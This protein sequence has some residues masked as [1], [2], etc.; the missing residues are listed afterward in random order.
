MKYVDEFR[1]GKIAEALALEI[2]KAVTRSWKIMEVC[3]GQTHTV[4]QF[5]LEDLLPAEIELLHGPGCPVC[6]TPVEVIDKAVAMARQP[7]VIMCSFGDMLRVPGS[8]GDLLQAKAEGADVRIVYCPLDALKLARKIPDRRIIFFAIGFET[9]APANAMAVYQAKRLGIKNFFML[10]SHVTVP[11]IMAAILE[12]PSN[13]VQA[14]LGPGHVCSIMGWS[15]YEAISR[16]Y[17]VPIVVT[18]FEPIDLLEGILYCVKQLEL[19]E[20]KVENQYARVVSYA[21]NCGAQSMLSDVFE[22]SDRQWR[23][24]GS[25]AKSGY[26][27]SHAYSQFDAEREF[28]VDAQ[29][30]AESPLCISGEILRGL[31]KPPQ[32]S[33]FGKQCTP[34]H[35]LGATMVS[36]EGTCATYFKF[37]KASSNIF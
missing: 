8:S 36:S 22:V 5:G 2:K 35:P 7:D 6:V 29:N 11:P 12:S 9:T 33:A 27:L 1:D 24:L 34:E 18:G 26:R 15:E 13:H 31:K 16:Q 4:L 23:G 25:V 19:G 3:G 17:G 21:G 10:C 30:V 32:C 28:Q 14:F 37:G 20:A